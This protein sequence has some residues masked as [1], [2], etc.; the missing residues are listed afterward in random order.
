[1]PHERTVG[2]AVRDGLDLVAFSGD[3]LLGGPQAGII[4]GRASL[5][6]RLRANPL[7]RAL[8]VD[9]ATVAAL[10]ATLRLYLEPGGVAKIPLYAMLGESVAALRE[11]ATTIRAKLGSHATAARVVDSEAFAGGGTLPMARLDSV[12]LAVR[13]PSGD[14][15]ALAAALRRAHPPI[16]GRVKDGELLLDLRTVRREHDAFV[17]EALARAIR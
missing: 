3:K 10:A 6:S 17:A 7:L 13:P 8:R 4:V 12:S 2:E 11:R 16:V 5:V 9:K 14:P 15:D 1:L